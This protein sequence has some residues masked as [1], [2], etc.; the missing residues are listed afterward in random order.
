MS[1]QDSGSAV[2]VTIEVVAWV[3]RFVGGDGT[4]RQV[5]QEVLPPGAGVREVLHRVCARFPR[6]DEALWEPGGRELAEHIEVLV[7]DTVLGVHHTL[8]SPLCSGDRITLIGA[9]TGGA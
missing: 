4:R 9:F 3:T 8:D 1:R 5:L 7:N 6:L 2:A